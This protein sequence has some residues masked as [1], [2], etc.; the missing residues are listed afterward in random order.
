MTRSEINDI[1]KD[2]EY[3][4]NNCGGCETCIQ[5][6]GNEELMYDPR[7]VYDLI[8]LIEKLEE[9]ITTLKELCR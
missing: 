9:E 2:I 7:T 4:A 8:L 1:K 5:I 6:F 3:Q